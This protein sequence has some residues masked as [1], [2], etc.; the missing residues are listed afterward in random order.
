MTQKPTYEELEQ[1]V[2]A[3]ERENA[4]LRKEKGRAV[5]ITDRNLAEE[6][7]RESEK[8][9]RRILQTATD[10]FWLIDLDGRLL[11]VNDAYCTMSGYTEEELLSMSISDLEALES[12]EE[13]SAHIEK[14]MDQS[15]DRFETQHRRK[16]GSILDVEVSVQFQ[17]EGR[18]LF[19]VFVRDIT[20]RKQV[21]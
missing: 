3:L 13:V 14:I 4:S 16:D 8:R 18:G 7:L 6:A 19:F 5:N 1:R 12:H 2:E 10:G 17:P 20:E 9:Y 21:E 11:D 15:G